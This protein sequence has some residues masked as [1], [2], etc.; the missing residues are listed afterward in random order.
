V[1]TFLFLLAWLFFGLRVALLVAVVW[2]AITVAL[3]VIDKR[4]AKGDGPG[5]S[6]L[7]ISGRAAA[8]GQERR[9]A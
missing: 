8:G 9:A 2:L 3:I 1:V 5:G 6:T 4:Q 7:P